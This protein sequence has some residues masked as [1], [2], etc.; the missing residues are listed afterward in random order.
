MK[1]TKLILTVMIASLMLSFAG[2]GETDATNTE[3]ANSVSEEKK[4]E[5]QKSDNQESGKTATAIKPEITKAGV[6]IHESVFYGDSD[7]IHTEKEF[8]K[9]GN[10][11]KCYDAESKISREYEYG[12]DGKLIK[13]SQAKEGDDSYVWQYDADGLIISEE[14]TRPAYGDVIESVYAYEF[15]GAG[16]PVA[17]SYQEG[18]FHFDAWKREYADGKLAK[19]TEFSHSTAYK[20]QTYMSGVK[21]Y[22]P[23]GTSKYTTYDEK[24][25]E[26]G[27]FEYDANGNITVDRNSEYEL[28]YEYDENNHVIKVFN[29]ANGT[30]FVYEYDYEGNQVIDKEIY[31]DGSESYGNTRIYAY[32]YD[33]FGNLVKSVRSTKAGEVIETVLYRIYYAD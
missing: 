10:L 21:E 22:A 19:E 24:G 2:C 16:N 3:S 8:D 6:V 4:A 9:N 15:D 31:S 25:N 13:E 14:W 5:S 18:S 12:D 33:E 28:D 30:T 29:T 11:I 1:K 32:E 20:G 23:D 27:Y 17:A 26:T 7:V